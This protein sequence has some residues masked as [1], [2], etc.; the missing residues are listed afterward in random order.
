MDYQKIYNKI[1]ENRKQNVPAGYSEKHHIIPRCLGGNDNAQNIVKLT[2]REHFICHYLLAKMYVEGSYEWYKTNHA[3]MIMKCNS[4]NQ[5][6]YYNSHL[7]ENLR[8]NMSKAMS[9]SQSKENNSQFKTFWIYNKDL[10]ENKKLPHGTE[11]P[12]GWVRGRKIKWKKSKHKCKQCSNEFEPKT[13]ELFCSK[14]CKI[15]FSD[16]FLNREKE[17][18][19]LY[20]K[21]NSMN[22]ALKAMGFPG[23]VSHYYKWAKKVLDTH[24]DS[25][26]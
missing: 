12:A 15:K 1:I 10:Q 16:P 13:K 22:R 9:L 18:M 23:A 25:R 4:L 20:K 26:G 24:P 17:F 11:I 14:E 3:F 7:Y 5:K 8:I 2:A 19:A 6:R 21:H